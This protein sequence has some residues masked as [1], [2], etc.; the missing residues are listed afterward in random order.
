MFRIQELRILLRG[1]SMCDRNG[2][3]LVL[4]I[5]DEELFFFFLIDSASSNSGRGGSE[6]YIARKT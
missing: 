6:D 4:F 1:F 3:L 5:H 2:M